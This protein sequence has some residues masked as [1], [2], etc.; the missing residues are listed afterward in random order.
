MFT[1]GYA[2]CAVLIVSL[3]KVIHAFHFCLILSASACDGQRS[4][5]IKP[6]H[7][8][9]SQGLI[10]ILLWTVRYFFCC[11]IVEQRS[12]ISGMFGSVDTRCSSCT[13]FGFVHLK[14][15]DM[16]SFVKVDWRHVCEFARSLSPYFA[17]DFICNPVFEIIFT[18]WPLMYTDWKDWGMLWYLHTWQGVCNV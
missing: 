2:D 17:V 1:I 9:S 5:D 4:R 14:I 3:W 11:V 8:C 12:D 10:T 15:R 18:G 6:Y 7:R 16:L 13:F